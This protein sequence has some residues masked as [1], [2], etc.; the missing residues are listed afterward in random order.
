MSPPPGLTSSTTSSI[1]IAQSTPATSPPAAPVPPDAPHT[2]VKAKS[3]AS[4]TPSSA[5]SSKVKIEDVPLAVPASETSLTPAQ[6][7]VASPSSQH[8]PI[9]SG[10]FAP[11]PNSHPNNAGFSDP[12]RRWSNSFVSEGSPPPDPKSLAYIPAGSFSNPLNIRP[13]GGYGWGRGRPPN[14]PP[15]PPNPARKPV[16]IGNG[17]PYSRGQNGN[18]GRRQ[19]SRR[20]MS[21]SAGGQ[22]PSQSAAFMQSQNPLGPP[23]PGLQDPDGGFFDGPSMLQPARRGR[24]TSGTPTLIFIFSV[25]SVRRTHV[26]CRVFSVILC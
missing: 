15:G 17:W 26:A 8:I 18:H 19:Q 13:S 20:S 16:P 10:L 9:P 12:R 6:G 21:G 11:P 25:A 14:Q 1:E 3:P 2:P 7:S 5:S 22:L 24:S 23:M 4:S